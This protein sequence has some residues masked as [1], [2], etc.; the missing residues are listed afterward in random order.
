MSLPPLLPPESPAGHCR[1]ALSLLWFARQRVAV[2][3]VP[4]DV[5]ALELIEAARARLWRAV[6]ALEAP[7]NAPPWWHGLRRLARRRGWPT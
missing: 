6:N 1:N 5:E 2:L 7:P 4:P 3:T